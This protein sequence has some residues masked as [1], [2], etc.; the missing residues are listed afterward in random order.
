MSDSFFTAGPD[1]DAL[2]DAIPESPDAPGSALQRLGAPPF[3]KS[4]FPFL[5]FLASVYDHVASHARGRSG[6]AVER[7]RDDTQ[8]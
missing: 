4:K 8:S 1:L 7:D 5:G 6:P 3:P 2:D